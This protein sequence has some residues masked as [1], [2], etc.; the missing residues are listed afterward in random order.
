MKEFCF[1]TAIGTVHRT[2]IF[3]VD[4]NVGYTFVHYMAFTIGMALYYR[5]W[6]Y[7]VMATPRISNPATCLYV[8]DQIH[9]HEFPE[10]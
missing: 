9:L 10:W 1:G 7:I 4:T 8:L 5:L 3:Y 6:H 2:G